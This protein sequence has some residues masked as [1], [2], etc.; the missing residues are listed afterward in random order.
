MQLPDGYHGPSAKDNDPNGRNALIATRFAY[1]CGKALRIP[2]DVRPHIPSGRSSRGTRTH[3]L[4]KA[5]R[6]IDCVFEIA[7]SPLMARPH[8]WP[9]KDTCWKTYDA[10][11][12]SQKHARVEEDSEGSDRGSP[13]APGTRRG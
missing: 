2:W 10:N 6:F 12:P 1:F 9:N 7:N 11:A 8:Q 5:E 13:S 4:V 3:D